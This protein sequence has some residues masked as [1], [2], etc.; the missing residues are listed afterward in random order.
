MYFDL[1]QSLI[2]LLKMRFLA[3]LKRDYALVCFVNALVCFVNALVCF[4]KTE[5]IFLNL[6]QNHFKQLP[7]A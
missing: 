6:V 7:V 4:F 3:L 2:R 1:Q 5:V